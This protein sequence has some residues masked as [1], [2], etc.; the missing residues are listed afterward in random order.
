MK[1]AL[2]TGGSGGIGYE[3]ALQ[4]AADGYQ[5]VLVAR[6]SQRLQQVASEI[7][8]KYKVPVHIIKID[9]SEM[10]ATQR[11]FEEVQTLGI[12]IDVLVNNAGFGVYG[13]YLETNGETELRMID[14]NMRTLTDLIKRFVPD[15]V[16][17]GTGGILNV[18][19][20]GAFQ[21]G[22]LMSVYF[23]T[24]AYV[25][26][27]TEALANELKGTGVVV[28]VL[29]PGMTKTEFF[30]TP[31]FSDQKQTVNLRR[32]ER[33]MMDASDVAAIGYRG[34]KK[35]KRVIISGFL[36]KLMAISS[37]I[38]PRGL[39]LAISRKL[40]ESMRS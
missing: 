14:L 37:K 25:L 17:R 35:G 4:F 40:T 16:R 21:P 2:I 26:S 32:V 11:L 1:T 19:S 38:S 29:C 6:N 8:G 28:S 10:V 30:V 7:T 34:F 36:N 3:L 31:A 15:M 13:S 39:V 5:V 20:T 33:M 9:L 18:A 27:Y 24:K 23:A 12:Q 22:P